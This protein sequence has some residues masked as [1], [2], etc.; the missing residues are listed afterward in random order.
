MDFLQKEIFNP[1]DFKPPSIK[2]AGFVSLLLLPFTALMITASMGIFS[3]G[4]GIKKITRAQSHCIQINLSGQKELGL[5]LKKILNLNSQVEFFHKTRKTIE[6]SM[7]IAAATGL[8]QLIPALKKKLNIIKQTQQ[9]LILRQNHLLAQ[10]FFV[11][12]KTFRNFKNQ[13]KKL[14][15]FYVQEK[16][17]YKK[18]LAVQKQKLGDKAYIYKPVPDLIKHQKSRFLWT[19]RPFSPNHI[20]WLL[21][22]GSKIPSNYTC[23]ASLSRKGDQWIRT[24]Y[25]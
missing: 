23:T 6:T 17:F 4:L 11:K 25:H 15:I 16:N 10:G 18:A 12:R 1:A 20:Q 3:L 9:A 5:L 14:K 2:R 22:V 13:L 24:L 8:V 21:P 19:M 7:A